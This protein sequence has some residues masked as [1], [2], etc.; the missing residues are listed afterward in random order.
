M[1]FYFYDT[2][3][4]GL[5]PKWQRIMQFAGIRTDE[6]FNEIG[7]PHNWLVKLTPEI[8]P[9]PEAIL[10]TG[11]TPQK[12]LEAGYSEP[13]FVEKLMREVFTHGTVA[14]GYN[15]VRFDDEFVRYTLYRN[16]FDPYE[17][18]WSDDRGRWDLVDL[19][20]MTRALRPDGI[21][22]PTSSEGR[23]TNR[24]EKL[25]VANGIAHDDAH[26]ALS[27][28]RATIGIAKLIKDKQPKLYSH[29]AGLRDKKAVAQL[30]KA[31]DGKPLVHSSSKFSSDFLGTSVVVVLAPHPSNP[32]AVLA[33]DLRHSPKEFA[34]MKPDELAE[35]AF[36]PYRQL[37][38]QEKTRLPVKAIHLNKS[39]ALAPIGVLD[40]DSQERIG[41]TL[42]KVEAHL[43]ELNAIEGFGDRVAQ[44]WDSSEFEEEEDVDTQLY[45]GFLNDGDRKLLQ[46]VRNRGADDL[47]DY[48]PNFS[49][50]RMT[51]LLLR[52][53]AKHF[54]SSLSDK[55]K[56][57]WEQ[58]RSQRLSGSVGP[59]GMQSYMT[60][61]AKLAEE[62]TDE[63]SRF[64]LEELQLYA[65]SVAP[66]ENEQLL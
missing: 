12:T 7:E 53:K 35:L 62:R 57:L 51:E 63:Q 14:L 42:K 16:F 4:S 31:N 38:E 17:R 44:A 21:E 30:L 20:R 55:E 40:E 58:Y 25:S 65:E 50:E 37:A 11:I 13:E 64:L 33:F 66:F 48:H 52:Y 54:P 41:L 56:Q 9:D 29:L 24:L 49:D 28:V 2:E 47:A 10:V 36:T 18:E 60:R 8:L 45:G 32:N 34:Y 27:D 22:W 6:D 23:A 1:T 39:P 5:N 15:S 61:L 26:D 46:Q 19:V 3:T 59:N 43:K